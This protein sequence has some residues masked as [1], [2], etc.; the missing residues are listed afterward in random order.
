M[1]KLMVFALV[2]LFCLALILNV[3]AEAAS[4][5]MQ[6]TVLDQASLFDAADLRYFSEL[7]GMPARGD[8]QLFLITSNCFLSEG[9]VAALCGADQGADVAALLIKPSGSSYYY[10]MFLFNRADKM[11]TWAES[12][13]ILYDAQVYNNIQSGL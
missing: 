11:L 10:E 12:D 6:V 5:A 13:A 7:Q 9:E 8:V 3:G 2:L 4:V 1:G